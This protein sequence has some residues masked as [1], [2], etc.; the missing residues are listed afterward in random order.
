MNVFKVVRQIDSIVG[1][2]PD[3]R[4]VVADTV[5][6]AIAACVRAAGD[7]L[8]TSVEMLNAAGRPVI[9]AGA[10][11]IKNEV[12]DIS[13]H[14]RDKLRTTT[15]T[16]VKPDGVTEGPPQFLTIDKEAWKAMDLTGWA[17]GVDPA[18]VGADRT[19]KFSP[20]RE[21]TAADIALG[22]PEEPCVLVMT[23]TGEYEFP[24]DKDPRPARGEAVIDEKSFFRP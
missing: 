1:N 16:T 23:D 13:G 6:D 10:A 19:V 4:Y 9:V 14:A 5:T 2:L 18:K 11:A 17:S 22:T 21:V 12:V 20:C 15:I 8:V 24:G 7:R 3:V